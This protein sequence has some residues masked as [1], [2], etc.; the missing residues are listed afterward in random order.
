M[1]KEIII[2]DIIIPT[3]SSPCDSWRAYFKKL[4]EK[5]GAVNARMIWLKTWEVNGSASCTTNA[6]FNKWLKQNDIDVSSAATRAVA[7]IS[8][9][10][11]NILGFGKTM[12][13]A[14]MIGVPAT[15]G[16]V[17]LMILIFL[18]RVSKEAKITD[19]AALHP[20]GRA[21]KLSGILK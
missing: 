13:K 14:M 2:Q 21:A 11:G 8:Q 18:F 7:D 19:L 1:A 6:N 4:K 9:V 17:V 10:G 15:L 3:S 12:T 20:A 5:F 16:V